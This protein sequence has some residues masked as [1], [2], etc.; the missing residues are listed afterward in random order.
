MPNIEPGRSFEQ[1]AKQMNISRRLPAFEFIAGAHCMALF[2]V[3]EKGLLSDSQNVFRLPTVMVFEDD[4]YLGALPAKLALKFDVCL[5]QPT[6]PEMLAERLEALVARKPDPLLEKRLQAPYGGKPDAF[7]ALGSCPSGLRPPP[8]APKP[9]PPLLQGLGET[10]FLSAGLIL[11]PIWVPP[12]LAYVG[13]DYL[14]EGGKIKL[15]SQLRIGNSVSDIIQLLG[16]PDDRFLLTAAGT[17]ILCYKRNWSPPLYLGIQGKRLIWQR[18]ADN[19]W[20]PK[21]QK[22]LEQ[23]QKENESKKQQAK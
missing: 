21:I 15:Q 9:L 22:Q 7:L 1:I 4:A 6:G 3:D 20:L 23:D 14:H 2:Y 8:P 13:A 5:G 19:D 12:C 10:L 11:L 17:E 16:E 18:W